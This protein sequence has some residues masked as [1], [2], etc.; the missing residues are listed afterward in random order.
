MI[1]QK[2]L[3]LL[4]HRGIPRRIFDS[5]EKVHAIQEYGGPTYTY[6]PLAHWEAHLLQPDI[7]DYLE[8]VA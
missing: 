8:T 6:R 5:L 1:N 4:K 7:R 3:Y 2:T